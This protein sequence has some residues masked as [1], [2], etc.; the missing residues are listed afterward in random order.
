MA[1]IALLIGVSNYRSDLSPLPAAVQDVKAM[2]RVIKEPTMGNFDEVKT[3]IDA[4]SQ[5]IRE[6]S[7]KLFAQRKKDDLVLF[8]FSGHGIKDEY[9]KLFLAAPETYKDERGELVRSSAVATRFLQDS[10]N[11]SRCKRQIVILDCCFSGAF[12]DGVSAKD[13]GLVD[14]ENELGG[15]GR[16]VLTSSTANQYSFEQRG[17]DLSIYTRYL[18]EGIETGAAD[19][20]SDGIISTQELHEYVR[21][22]VQAAAPAMKPKIFTAEEGFT[23][24][25]SQAPTQ[26]PM[27]QYR[28]EVERCAKSGEIS[29]VAQRVLRVSRVKL[30][31]TEPQAAAIQVEVLEPYRKYQQS[32][33]QYEQVFRAELSRQNPL[34][35]RRKSELLRL[36]ELLKLLDED[37]KA[38]EAQVVAEQEAAEFVR[39]Q[40]AFQA[41]SST[42]QSIATSSG[43]ERTGIS[44]AVQQSGIS[45]DRVTNSSPSRR[46]QSMRETAESQAGGQQ[47]FQSTS[48]L[49]LVG[50]VG[51][52]LAAAIAGGAW[53]ILANN[54]EQ[55]RPNA[56]EPIS[57]SPQVISSGQIQL[58]E[59]S[60]EILQF[61]LDKEAGKKLKE[62]EEYYNQGEFYK[63][64][65][66]L[67]EILPDSSKFQD[68]QE[69]IDWWSKEWSQNTALTEGAKKALADGKLDNARRQANSIQINA[70]YWKRMRIDLI[71]QIDAATKP[72]LKPSI[73]E[74]NSEDLKLSE[75]MSEDECSSLRKSYGEA[76]VEV[77][78]AVNADGSNIR[79]LCEEYGINFPG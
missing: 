76:D 68:A 1:K 34:S 14:I 12:G 25:L 30:G 65:D 66:S 44:A 71:A 16:A 15:E 78:Q 74:E 18:V 41:N 58:K 38:V 40:G 35:L 3:L 61:K 56:L 59:K 24:S 63:A 69:R 67:K 50:I 45:N 31:I 72:L 6:T 39:P 7:E 17:A 70:D 37:I 20:D 54:P 19:E 49:M 60:D 8:F 43:L 53:K 21:R 10:M 64:L 42:V 77:R 57:P 26:D 27:L 4:N 51:S 36:Q 29:A 32:L 11:R 46:R 28:R 23:I 79:K 47:R 52:V 55:S 9:G 33:R 73:E 62:A 5:V 48:T 2:V 75:S 22:K 13:D